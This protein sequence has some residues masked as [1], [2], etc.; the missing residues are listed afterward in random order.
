M[1]LPH[2][3]VEAVDIAET[4]VFFVLLVKIQLFG[5]FFLLSYHHFIL[6]LDIIFSSS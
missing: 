2:L 6:K 1:P 4:D 5:E 3:T